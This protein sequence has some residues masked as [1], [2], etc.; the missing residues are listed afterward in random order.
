[1]TILCYQVL[2]SGRHSF[3]VSANSLILPGFPLTSFHLV[4][5]SFYAFSWLY[6]LECVV[7]QKFHEMSLIYNHLHFTHFAINLFSL[8]NMKT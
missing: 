7:V 6:V 1:M 3:S 5:A 2:P 4:E 8:H